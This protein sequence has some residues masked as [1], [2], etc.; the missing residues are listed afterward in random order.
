MALN[1]GI[2][3]VNAGEAGQRFQLIAEDMRRRAER[4]S[5]ETRRISETIH[6][7]QKDTHTAAEASLAGQ[8]LTEQGVEKLTQMSRAFDDMYELI[9]RTAEAS[10]RITHDTEVQIAAIHE[11]ADAS[12]QARNRAADTSD[13]R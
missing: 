5:V 3:A 2:E 11:L 12:L 7:V 10:M 6:R 1:T 9:E 13:A 4:V 8:A